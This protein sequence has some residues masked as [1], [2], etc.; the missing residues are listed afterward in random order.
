MDEDAEAQRGSVGF[1]FASHAAKS[2]QQSLVGTEL[3]FA[4]IYDRIS[5]GVWAGQP[6]GFG[7]HKTHG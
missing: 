4:G 7:K 2:R 6:T 5:G 3:Q 1:S